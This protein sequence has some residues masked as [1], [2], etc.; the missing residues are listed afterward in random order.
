MARLDSYTPFMFGGRF[1][2][3]GT[4]RR[5]LLVEEAVLTRVPDIETTVL[6]TE[7]A[8]PYVVE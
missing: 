4:L 5:Y 7:D 2:Y 8:Q 3:G 6:H 1:D